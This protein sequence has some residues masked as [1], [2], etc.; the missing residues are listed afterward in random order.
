[1][2]KMLLLVAA[3]F[4]ASSAS[5]AVL[6]TSQYHV[7]SLAGSWMTGSSGWNLAGSTNAAA[8][9]TLLS[10]G[11]ADDFSHTVVNGIYAGYPAASSSI[12]FGTVGGAD[13]MLN[14][15][16]FITTRN[17]ANTTTVTLEYALNGGSWITAASTTTGTLLAPLSSCLNGM[18][19]DCVG[20]NATLNFGGV[21]ADQWRLSFNGSQVSLHEVIVDTGAGVPATDIP[22]PAS[23]A[24]VGL[25]LL[26][27]SALRRKKANYA[28]V[29]A[30]P[31][32]PPGR[33]SWRRGQRARA[34]R[35]ITRS[36]SS[37][38]PSRRP[39]C[40]RCRHQFSAACTST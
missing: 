26:G 29:C 35:F 2:K 28:L 23:L 10:N 25:G 20:K 37:P 14:T 36:G 3:L 30:R 32:P 1:M 27:V 11:Y 31:G 4:A 16:S 8:A 33:A 17:Y 13:F 7:T 40:R 5:A 24:L 12:V 39:C 9:D 38:G 18:N 15:F 19:N 34:A 21:L 22:E 6:S